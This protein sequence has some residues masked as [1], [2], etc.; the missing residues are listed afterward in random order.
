MFTNTWAYTN[1]GDSSIDFS[2]SDECF[3][4]KPKLKE[5]FLSQNAIDEENLIS[6]FST[7]RWRG[8]TS[9]GIVRSA[10]LDFSVNFTVNKLF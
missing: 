9:S 2:V 10:S 3:K 5:L 6:S 8:N 7:P 1:F 4:P